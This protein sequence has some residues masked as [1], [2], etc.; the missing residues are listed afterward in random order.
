MVRMAIPDRQKPRRGSGCDEVP[1]PAL[2]ET[3]RRGIQ[4]SEN[5]NLEE[6]GSP[7]KRDRQEDPEAIGVLNPVQEEDRR[8][9]GREENRRR[10][11]NTTVGGSV[12][13][14]PG[15]G[16]RGGETPTATDTTNAED[17]LEKGD[18]DGPATFWKNMAHSGTGYSLT[19]TRGRRFKI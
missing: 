16:L 6:A 14:G 13:A 17:A 8:N 2:D 19:G 5:A 7:G 4:E 18:A 3:Y 9:S 1:E 15:K 11:T 10:T 12:T